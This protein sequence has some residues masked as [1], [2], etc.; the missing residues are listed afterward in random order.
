M[1]DKTKLIYAGIIASAI[2]IS[3]AVIGHAY[4]NRNSNGTIDVTGLGETDFMSDLIVWDGNFSEENYNLQTAYTNLEKTKGIIRKYLKIKGVA[5][6]CIVFSA[7]KTSNES[8]ADY[9]PDGKYLGNVFTGY[10]LSQEVKVESKD[11]E[12]IE[13]IAREVTEL[14]NEG[15]KFYSQSPR[16]YYTKLANVKLG[17]ISSAT[18]DAKKRAEQ[19]ATKSGAGLGEVLRANM[20]VF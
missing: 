5:D 3:A 1:N 15:V 20:G 16:Y 10:R 11:V 2:I 18:E 8:R 6:S 17:L 7:V 4:K 12:K 9:S 19:I 14:L 13:K